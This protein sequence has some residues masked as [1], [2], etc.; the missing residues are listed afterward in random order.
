MP[1]LIPVMIK[2]PSGN[3]LLTVNV[4]LEYTPA[5]LLAEL[6][7]ASDLD[8]VEPSGNLLRYELA[9]TDGKAIPT[10]A[11]FF[12]VGYYAASRANQDRSPRPSSGLAGA[13]TGPVGTGRR[14]R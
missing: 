6:V 13:S 10:H 14:P 1:S 2:D 11:N 5:R 12:T 3:L 8:L 7:E 4:P 9:R